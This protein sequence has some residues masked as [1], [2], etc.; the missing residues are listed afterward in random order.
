MTGFIL[1][2][3]GAIM[4]LYGLSPNV[5]LGC[6]VGDCPPRPGNDLYNAYSVVGLVLVMTGLMEV[7]ASWYIG[8]NHSQTHEVT[9][10]KTEK[11]IGHNG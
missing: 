9:A 6:P 3:L 8:R 2:I 11:L 4:V 7:G 10:G 5:P 1:L